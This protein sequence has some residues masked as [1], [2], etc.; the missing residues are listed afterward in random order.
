MKN[1][2]AVFTIVKNEYYFLPKWINHYSK[3][4]DKKDLYILDH[5]SNDGSTENLDVNVKKVINNL[6]F[7]HEWLVNTVRSFQRELLE[8][9]ECVI[10]AES[11][12]FLYSLNKD[13]NLIIDDFLKTNEPYITSIGYEVIQDIQNEKFLNDSEE[14]MINRNNWFRHTLYDKTL[15][16]K[17][18]LNWEYGFHNITES[19][20]FKFN[21]YLAHLHRHDL[22][23]M[24]KRHQERSM[25]WN[26]KDDKNHGF[27]HKIKEESEI[28]KYFQSIPSEIEK[29]PTEHKK[30]LMHI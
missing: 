23:L 2:C 17:I 9:Y 25:K 30:L 20:N 26:L 18:P 12:E 28:F 19:K 22:K 29:I 13:L 21:L 15:I 11:D 10:F 4:F 14:I 16:S 7:D 3:F 27:Q 24:V 1:K 6:A 5:E 8:K